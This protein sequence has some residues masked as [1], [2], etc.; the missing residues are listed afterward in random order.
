MVN[1]AS[2]LVLLEFGRKLNKPP[3]TVVIGAVDA[4]D[5]I[6]LVAAE[7]A[8]LFASFGSLALEVSA[9]T[10]VPVSGNTCI[11]KETKI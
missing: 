4:Y 6:G 7:G 2:V 3:A 11:E 8:L 9:R 1:L 5:N 10:L